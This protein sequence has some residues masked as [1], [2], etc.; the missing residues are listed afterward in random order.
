MRM[1]ALG[2][3]EAAFDRSDTHA[4]CSV[5][6]QGYATCSFFDGLIKVHERGSRGAHRVGVTA[7]FRTVEVS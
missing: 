1:M 7:R 5:R 4:Y 3:I 6:A 2:P